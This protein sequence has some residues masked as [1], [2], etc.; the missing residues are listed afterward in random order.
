MGGGCGEELD[1]KLAEGKSLPEN[2]EEL[3]Y[4]QLFHEDYR[5]QATFS[6]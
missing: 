2:T 6:S 4:K 5:L 1:P 3:L